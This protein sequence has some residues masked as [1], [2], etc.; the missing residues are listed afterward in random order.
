[1]SWAF[2][3]AQVRGIDI[4]VH[5]TFFLILVLGGIQW[6]GSTPGNPAEGILFGVVLTLLLFACVTLHELGHSIA[7]QYYNIPVKEIVLLPLGGVALISKNPEKPLHELIIAAAGP[8]VNVVIAALLFGVV[9]FTGMAPTSMNDL[10]RLLEGPSLQTMLL[11]LLAANVSL[12]LFNLIPAFPLDGGRIL[13][14]L[15]AMGIGMPRAT[16]IASVIGQVAAIGLGIWGITSGNFLLIIIA[17]FIFMGAG[18][19]AAMASATQASA[20]N[21][22]HTMRVGDAYNKHALQLHIG[23][24]VSKVVDYILTSYQPDFAVMQGSN[25]LGIVTRDDVLRNLSIDPTDRYVTEIMQRNLLRIDANRSLDEARQ[26][27]AQAGARVAAVFDGNQQFLGLVNA[28][29]IG[30]AFA[31]LTFVERQQ[32]LRQQ[33]NSPPPLPR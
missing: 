6:A 32:A 18:Q 31:V 25:V 11:W 33:R 21:V 19:E 4:K 14:A 20:T 24:R 27:M 12:V 26:M 1:M 30:E 29:D 22:L 8:L 13:R 10:G 9:A 3:I 5:I 28:D 15:L 7:A 2:R 16:R 23:D 17:V